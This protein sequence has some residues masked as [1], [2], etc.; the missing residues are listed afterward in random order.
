MSFLDPVR[1]RSMVREH[2][3]RQGGE[4]IWPGDSGSLILLDLHNFV[5]AENIEPLLDFPDPWDLEDLKAGLEDE[6]HD[7]LVAGLAF[8]GY[9]YSLVSY[10]MPFDLVVR[11]IE[12]VTRW[13]V[14]EPKFVAPTRGE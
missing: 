9:N 2:I 8:L 6:K 12:S 5:L 3:S 10:M 13:E 11:D 14:A 4:F 7:A 1:C